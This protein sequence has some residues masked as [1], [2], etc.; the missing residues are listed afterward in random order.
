VSETN[1]RPAN[2]RKGW[3]R[4]LSPKFKASDATSIDQKLVLRLSGRRVPNWKQMKHLPRYLTK[5]DRLVMA[6]FVFVI[7]VG[8]SAL[9]VKAYSDHVSVVPAAGG[10]YVEAAVGGPR[11][12]NPVLAAGNDADNDLIALVYSGLMRYTKEGQ[13]VPD[14]AESY[15]ISDDG[16]T[17]VFQLKHL[18]EWHDGTAFTAGDVVSTFSYLK[19]PAWESPYQ[20]RFKNVAVEMI[21]EHS[22][23]FRLQQAYAP[24]LSMLTIGIMPA[25]LWEEV[26]PENA[27]RA[28]LNIKPV[29]TG[30]FKFKSL[31]K[32]R[33]GTVKSLTLT[34]N[35]RYY[36]QLP[37]LETVS[38]RYYFDFGSAADALLQ[39]KVDGLSFLPADAQ[40]QVDQLRTIR[41]YH[42]RLPQYTAVFFNANKLPQ[43]KSAEVRQALL[44]ALD[45]PALIRDALGGAGLPAHSPILPG[46]LGFRQEIVQ[47]DYDQA[48]A[49]EL[50]TEAG[51]ELGEDGFRYKETKVDGQTSQ[52]FLRIALTTVDVKENLDAA[53]LIK[54]AW[55]NI[56]VR[57]ELDVVNASR[58]QTERIR[59]REYEALLYGVMSGPGG[60]PFPF[61]H[62]SQR[63][64]PGLNLAGFNNRRADELLEQGRG[65]LDE[66]VRA[67]KYGEF[68]EIVNEQ[69]PAIFLYSPTYAY[70]VNRKVKGVFPGFVMT[71]SGRLAGI[72]DWSTRTKR[73]WR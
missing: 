60:D 9:V 36:G 15:E 55:E 16:L 72:S 51:W 53:Q 8:L 3:L 13:L 47:A 28:E 50:L 42:L 54:Q 7:L 44:Q 66:T 52:Q 39:N 49:A 62:S 29:G 67:E 63:N 2:G 4:R 10:S 23:R 41:S 73:V 26:L 20:S 33:K 35:N 14:L 22:V 6:G 19:N 43:I 69:V 18:V 58:V 61:W 59:P 57:V 30:P 32:D 24:F 56:G 31:T 68:L 27:A 64:A 45:R 1:G 38:F 70:V 17:Y 65:E 25:H 48:A 37:Y 71:P 21:D 11:Y 12:I 46:F 5:R 34:R 40:A